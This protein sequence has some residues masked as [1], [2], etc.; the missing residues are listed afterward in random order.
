MGKRISKRVQR[1]LMVVII[2][3]LWFSNYIYVPVLSTYSSSVG[4]SLTMVGLILS[5]YGLAQMLLR[6]PFGLLSDILEN[7]RLFLYLGLFASLISSLCFY[8][9][10][11][12]GMLLLARALAGVAVSNWAI[13]VTTYGALDEKD[14]S[15]RSIGIINSLMALGQILGVFFGGIIAQYLNVKWTFTISILASFIGLVLLFFI[16]ETYE[17]MGEKV[18]LSSFILVAKDTKLLFYSMMALLLQAISTSS[19][20][21]FV[22]T[23][24]NNINA[25]DFEKGLGT[26]LAILPAT[27]AAPLAVGF[28]RRQLGAKWTAIAGFAILSITMFFFPIIISTPL[29]LGILFIAGCGRGL[30]LPLFMAQSVAHLPS[31]TRSTALSAFQAIYGVG[32]WIGPAI[33]GFISNHFSLGIAFISLSI[34]GFA[35]ILCLLLYKDNEKKCQPSV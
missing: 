30:L 27:F 8:F 10:T 26:T 11:S 35:A 34:I 23:L 6:I 22:P 4:A 28:L 24:L 20:T 3:L 14:D 15:S 16:D 9:F 21:G 5:S 19:L 25:S 2:L 33:T 7:R 1:K 31:E 32:M 18:K 13:F 29:M 12:S 17:S